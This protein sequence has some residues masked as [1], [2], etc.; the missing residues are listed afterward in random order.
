M[1]LLVLLIVLLLLLGQW[2]KCSFLSRRESAASA[3]ATACFVRM[4]IPWLT[5]RSAA[6]I[7]AWLTGAAGMGDWTLLVVGEAALAAVFC[8]SRPSQRLKP[9]RLY[10]VL[11]AAPALCLLWAQWLFS[12]PGINFTRFA[13]WA[14]LLS[15]LWVYG[16]SRLVRRLLPEESARLEALF[17][18]AFFLVLL[19]VAA[20][21][22]L[23]L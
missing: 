21:G 6:G 3:L 5:T 10:P 11:L 20:A 9:L 13:R 23:T 22:A 2:L 15:A 14:A 18:T 7:S 4:G 16:G 19:T 1:E 17:L 12:R 8:F